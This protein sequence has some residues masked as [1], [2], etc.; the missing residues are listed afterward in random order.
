MFHVE[1]MYNTRLT[2]SRKY[3]IL[4]AM[5]K[6]NITAVRF[7]DSFRADLEQFAADLEVPL[8]SLLRWMVLYCT[9]LNVDGTGYELKGDFVKFAERQKACTFFG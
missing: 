8:S 6:S 1:Q 4:R 3:D 9:R 2:N 7:S 5:K